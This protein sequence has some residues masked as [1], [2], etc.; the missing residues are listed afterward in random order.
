MLFSIINTLAFSLAAMALGYFVC[1][2]ASKE[3]GFLKPLGL[4]LGAVIIIATFA[5][6]ILIAGLALNKPAGMARQQNTLGTRPMMPPAPM[7]PRK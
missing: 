2:K 5:L 7:P 6:S 4:V 1:L 3:Q